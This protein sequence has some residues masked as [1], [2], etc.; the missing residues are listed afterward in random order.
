MSFFVGVKIG[1]KRYPSAVCAAEEERREDGQCHYLIRALIR[2]PIGTSHINIAQRVG[3][4][5]A[6]IR[7]RSRTS[8]TTYVDATG[9][10]QPVVDAVE[11]HAKQATIK[12]VYF[13]HGDRRVEEG[14]VVTLGKAYLVS[15]LQVLLESGR[16]HLPRT[17]E[18]E[19]WTQDLLE[20]ELEVKP[21]ANDQY[22]TFRVGPHD[23]L[24]TALGLA[25]QGGRRIVSAVI[26]TGYGR[27]R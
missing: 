19:A 18:R 27:D 11:R 10:G 13:N 22:G 24:I 14:D 6:G 9:L 15:R 23:E 1:Q 16:L 17:P 2:L 7:Q 3:Q 21:D 8:I 25:V 4:M 20:Y 26:R 12:P 5:V